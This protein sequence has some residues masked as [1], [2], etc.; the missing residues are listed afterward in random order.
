MQQL[1][2]FTSLFSRCSSTLKQP[3]F[4]FSSRFFTTALPLLVMS[5]QMGDTTFPIRDLP[6]SDPRCMNDSCLAFQ[7]AHNLSQKET[8]YYFQYEYGH[9]TAWYYLGFIGIFMVLH[10]LHIWCSRIT[11]SRRTEATARPSLYKKALASVRY[12]SYRRLSSKPFDRLGLPS[13]GLRL[14]LLLAVL[15]LLICTFAVRPYYRKHRG[16]GSPPLAVRTG[17]MAVACTPLI[18]ALAG[19]A[20]IATLL[21]GIGHEKLNTVHRW[22]AWMCFGL[23]VTH[24]VPF[25]VAPLRDGGYAAL[26]KQFYKL[27]SFEVRRRGLA[28]T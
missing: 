15:F 24:T 8:L 2:H 26:H 9:W 6:L 3:N 25:I 14:F 16:Y 21:T 10:A 28:H 20:N 23:S 22:V 7:A 4:Q 12:I 11:H 13:C 1:F 19:K 17:L 5:V 27:G 18:V